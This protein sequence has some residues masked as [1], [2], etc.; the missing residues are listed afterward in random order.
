M[1]TIQDALAK[2][3]AEATEKAEIQIIQALHDDLCVLAELTKDAKTFEEIAQRFVD[4]DLIVTHNPSDSIYAY[5]AV[6]EVL[7][8]KVAG[9]LWMPDRDECWNNELPE[10][11]EIARS[12]PLQ[13]FLAK[14]AKQ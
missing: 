3:I 6:T 11:I 7:A 5:E 4:N 8:L 1:S 2:S 12:Q 10:G 14:E 13:D 9:F